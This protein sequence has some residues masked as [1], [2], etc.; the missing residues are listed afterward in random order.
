MIMCMIL[1]ATKIGN[2][3][4]LD[5]SEYNGNFL[6][7]KTLKISDSQHRLFSTSDFIVEKTRNCFGN[8]RMPWI[9]IHGDIPVNFIEKGYVYQTDFTKLYLPKFEYMVKNIKIEK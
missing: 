9:M 6:D 5:C 7:S 8:G 4:V 2:D 3:T 1:N